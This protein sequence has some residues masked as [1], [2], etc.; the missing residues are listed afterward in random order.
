MKKK[1][2]LK[3]AAVI[4]SVLTLAPCFGNVAFATAPEEE[5]HIQ[6]KRQ[7]C[8]TDEVG[9]SKV[10]KRKYGS[11]NATPEQVARYIVDNKATQ[12][13]AAK[14]FGVSVSTIADCL[15]KLIDKNPE[16][17]EKTNEIKRRN[18]AHPGKCGPK[19]KHPRKNVTN[20]TPNEVARYIISQSII[21]RRRIT[22]QEVANFFNV[23]EGMIC[24][25]I[26]QLHGTPLYDNVMRMLWRMPTPEE[27]ENSKVSKRQYR[28]MEVAP[29][30]V[31]NFIVEKYRLGK[32]VTLDQVCDHFGLFYNQVVYCMRKLK[33]SNSELYS[34]AHEI[35]IKNKRKV[36]LK[37][38]RGY[39]ND[40]IISKQGVPQPCKLRVGEIADYFNVTH[41]AARNWLTDLEPTFPGLYDYVECSAKKRGKI[42][43]NS[44]E[45]GDLNFKEGQSQLP[46]IDEIL[47][48]I[49]R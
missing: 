12:G 46:H 45:V 3:S 29:E 42:K 39:I 41:T 23:P 11:L 17:L 18:K 48:F 40:Y 36:N 13:Q 2:L 5:Q 27:V 8:S 34:N 49:N 9:N 47:N 43:A 38:V 28:R 15:K 1:I 14:Y 22:Y 25:C 44:E 6:C 21:Q 4:M 24:N 10:N 35:L 32:Q 37:D 33:N 20:V 30:A 7:R 26:N 19:P 16:L 31:G